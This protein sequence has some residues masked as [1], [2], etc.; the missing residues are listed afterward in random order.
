MS[1]RKSSKQ[2]E[3]KMK[4]PM[5]MSISS[6]DKFDKEML[7]SGEDTIMSPIKK[8][9]IEKRA[10]SPNFI[11]EPANKREASQDLFYNNE[12]QP[13]TPIGYMEI[14]R[15]NLLYGKLN[16]QSSLGV[17]YAKY[18]ELRYSYYYY[19]SVKAVTE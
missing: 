12:V 18:L 2:F 7:R 13:Q 11:D 3:S 9:S 1:Q 5:K 19:P 16:V 4:A 15:K 6:K 8:F 17:E 10:P 14:S